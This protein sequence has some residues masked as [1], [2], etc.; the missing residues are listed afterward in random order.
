VSAVASEL[1][2]GSGT[3][4]R[5][6]AE[7]AEGNGPAFVPVTVEAAPTAAGVVVH[8]AHGLRIE[9]LDVA[10]LAELLRRLA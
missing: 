8:T 3:L 9:G 4:L 6:A 1:G 10:A 2:V 7:P 5:W